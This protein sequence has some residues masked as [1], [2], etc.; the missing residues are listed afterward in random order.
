VGAEG[1]GFARLSAA[2]GEPP[3]RP[4]LA[5]GLVAGLAGLK[6]G[7]H[8]LV[9]AITPYG[10]HRDELLYL[11]M[12]RHLRLW[13]MDFPPAIALVAEG[14]RATLGDSLQA[15]RLVPALAGTAVLVL[16]AVIARELGGGRRAQGLAALAVLASPLFLRSANLFQPVVLD[17]LAWTAALYALVRLCREPSRHGWLLLGGALGLGL[18]VKFSAAFVGVAIALALLV[19]GRR[20]LTTPWPWIAALLALA[21]GSPSL[22]GQLRLGFP[23]LGQ[24]ADLR[25]SQL[26]RVT[27]LDFFAGQL[28]W[29]PATL[30]GL[31]GL[32]ALL[33]DGRLRRFRAVGWACV[34]VFMILLVLHGKSY[35]AG[36][37]YPTLIAAG[38]VELERLQGA[39][40][41]PILRGGMAAALVLTLVA[42]LPIGVPVIPPDRMARYVQAI[43]ATPALRTN[44]GELDRLP[45]DYADM[46]GWEEQVR[47][48]AEVYRRLPPADRERAVLLGANYGE[49]GALDLF[50]PR[51][52]LPAVVSPAGS[53]WFFGPGTRPGQVLVT[54]GVDR[55]RLEREFDSV[56]TAGRVTS[57]WSVAE[58]RDLTICVARG[59]HR[60]LQEVWPGL[61]GGTEQR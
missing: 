61:G 51:Y 13:R 55:S 16:A 50:G 7:L 20:L 38:A 28:L 23:V 41:G 58:E 40:L 21:I 18:L 30:L 26:E 32:A 9:N 2:T 60:T 17:Q 42:L 4:P 56:E 12:G 37:V 19:A 31:A 33:L 3:D 35:Y 47:A 25:A 11:A 10:F 52:G 6:L 29:G 46:L 48:V 57:P 8:V 54:I 15:I 59:P 45:Q 27:P 24:M 49:A 1:K 44:T 39:R 22:V 34:W 36:P 53:F 5:R 43:G 14:V